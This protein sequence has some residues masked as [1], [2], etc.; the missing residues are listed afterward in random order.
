MAEVQQKMDSEAPAMLEKP[1]VES[2]PMVETEKSTMENKP[3]AMTSDMA[4]STPTAAAETMDTN[5]AVKME[6]ATE[7]GILG[8]KAPGLVK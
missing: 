3:D 4:E 5:Q 2:T 6:A 1:T 8:Y 7:E